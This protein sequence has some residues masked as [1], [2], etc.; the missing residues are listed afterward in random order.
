MIKQL[1]PESRINNCDMN[2]LKYMPKEAHTLTTNKII[3]RKMNVT[4]HLI[5]ETSELLIDS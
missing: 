1:A 3:Y 2:T 4:P 5:R